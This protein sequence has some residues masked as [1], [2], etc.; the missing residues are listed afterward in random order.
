MRNL[1]ESRRAVIFDV[2]GTLYDHGLVKRKILAALGRYYTVRPWRAYDLK[3]LA[4]FRNCR[5]N[6]ARQEAVDLQRQQFIH[7]ASRLDVPVERVR[8]LVDRWIME[9]PLACMAASR[10]PGVRRFLEMLRER[11]IKLAVFS[12]YPAAGK[13]ASLDLSFDLIVS[14]V[15][16]EVD[17]FK[18]H[19]AGLDVI[20]KKLGVSSRDCLMIGDRVDKDGE[21]ARRAGMPFLHKTLRFEAG[22]EN[23][24]QHY[25]SLVELL[26]C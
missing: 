13:V 14:S 5:E 3:I 17:R 7:C 1:L 4:A 23:Q 26:G 22:G 15:D 20:A 18:P 2:D 24:F 12:D 6:L 10:Y 8:R 16:P 11:G 21:C 25:D 19:P 9:E